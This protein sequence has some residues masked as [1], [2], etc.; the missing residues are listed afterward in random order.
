MFTFLGS[1]EAGKP[2]TAEQINRPL[3]GHV[4]SRLA[5][6]VDLTKDAIIDELR[7][8]LRHS[9]GA[10]FKAEAHLAIVTAERDELAERL[11]LA[12]SKGI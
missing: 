5:S 7:L 4:W 9:Q 11:K 2:Q 3:T 6:P 1:N 10:R 12:A 8:R